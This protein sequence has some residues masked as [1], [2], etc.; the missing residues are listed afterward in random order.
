MKIFY[1]IDVFRKDSKEHVST[2]T[3]KHITEQRL[4]EIFFK[5]KSY[6]FI[7]EHE[8]KE[9]H[10]KALTEFTGNIF[11]LEKYIYFIGARQDMD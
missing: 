2:I 10:V 6:E 7:G 4:N 3:V 1:E 11:D 9:E 5:D 8:I